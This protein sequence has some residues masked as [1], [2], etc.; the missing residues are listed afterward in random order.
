M[1]AIVQFDNKKVAKLKYEVELQ[2][3][4]DNGTDY[5]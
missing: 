1:N 5:A 3:P 4:D 2:L